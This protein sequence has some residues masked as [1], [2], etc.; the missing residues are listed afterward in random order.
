MRSLAIYFLSDIPICANQLVF[1]VGL[2]L[3]EALRC[4][5]SFLVFVRFF[6][7]TIGEIEAGTV[8]SSRDHN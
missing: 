2:V 3:T 5:I 7:S 8:G 1:V 6:N 4:G